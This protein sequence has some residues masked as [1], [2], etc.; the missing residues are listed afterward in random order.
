MP[1]KDDEM[2]MKVDWDCCRKHKMMKAWAMLILGAL[3]LVNA[4]WPFID[5]A[6]FIGALLVLAGIAK[7][8]MPNKHA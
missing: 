8:I 7:L 3:V 5:W 1:K 6:G 4:Y 2:M